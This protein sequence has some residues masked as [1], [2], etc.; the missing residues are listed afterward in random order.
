MEAQHTSRI[1]NN[2]YKPEMEEKL[3]ALVPLAKEFEQ[4]LDAY[5]NMPIRVQTVAMRLLKLHAQYVQGLA[6]AMALKS[7]GK[8]SDAKDAALAFFAEFGKN[9]VA[10]ERYY[11]HMLC[12]HAL[13]SI[14]NT[15]SE[16]AQ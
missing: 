11:D 4:K 13:N 14:F 10:W 2:F 15:K 12:A 1:P 8:D 7:L 3:L 5:K 9:E 6:Q 16:Y